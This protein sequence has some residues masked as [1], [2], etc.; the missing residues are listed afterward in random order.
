MID[1][2]KL[3]DYTQYLR[4]RYLQ[5]FRELSW[6]EVVEDRGASFGSIKNIFLHCVEVLSI[7]NQILLGNQSITRINVDEYDT[8][9]KVSEY[10]EQIEPNFNSYLA[11]LT[12]EELSRKV[13][14]KRRDGTISIANVEDTL[15][16]VFEEEIH[17]FGE[18]IALLWQMDV[19][20][21]HA[22]YT[23]YVQTQE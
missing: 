22:A 8:I 10:M 23:Q 17:H 16:H 3:L 14:R 21:P 15:I 18:F 4:H 2:V 13:E 7:F 20:P 11:K 12:P 1:I 5:T 6:D 19:T 9:E